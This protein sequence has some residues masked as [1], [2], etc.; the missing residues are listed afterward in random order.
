MVANL[1]LICDQSKWFWTNVS[2]EELEPI[3]QRTRFI[4]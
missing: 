4:K 2:I 3:V 1:E